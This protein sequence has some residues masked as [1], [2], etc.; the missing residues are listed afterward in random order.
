VAAVGVLAAA[1]VGIATVVTGGGDQG[2]DDLVAATTTA[3]VVTRDL[4]VTDSY[5]GQLGYGE[6]RLYVTDRAGVVTTVAAPG[7]TVPVGGS[8]FSIDFEPTVVLSGAVPAYRA[9][10]ASV[11]DGPDVEQLEAGLV[12][13]GHG[14]GVTVDE[15]FDAGTTAAVRRWEAALH[16]ADPDGVVALGDVTFAAGEVR[17]GTISAD[18]GSRVQ[19]GSTILE[20]T[21]TAHVV[22][23][24]LA[25]SRSNELEPGT[26]VGLTLPDGVE[27]T[28]KVATIG[29][30][31]SASDGQDRQ[32]P[33][34]SSEPTVPV[35]ITLDD[36]TTA[37]AFD[38]GAVDVA[39]ERSREEGATAVPVEALLALV[40][41][42]Y[43]VEVADGTSSHL[44]GVEVGT[45]ADGF[46]GVTGDGVEAGV[47]VV[48]PA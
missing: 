48:V 23:V 13:L 9:L 40:E 38:T 37:A 18:V 34:A 26:A 35:T 10:D 1:G 2:D 46:V 16:R 45:F 29:S 20:A 6:A 25:A 8:L 27:T 44:V 33:D 42:G 39:L 3:E 19:D 31:S 36:P 15:H 17:V 4:V 47:E 24:G 43:A 12:A 30:P 41:G 28:G 32:G 14:A 21:P 7:R 22:T 11:G 5:E